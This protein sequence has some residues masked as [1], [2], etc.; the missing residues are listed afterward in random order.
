MKC[1]CG[2]ELRGELDTFGPVEMPLC[3]ECFLSKRWQYGPGIGESWYGLAPHHHRPGPVIGSTVFDP[4]EYDADGLYRE[5]GLTFMPDP[6]A[7]G[8]GIWTRES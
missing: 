7:P 5:D 6:D 2:K 4:V 3:W 8:C 1:M